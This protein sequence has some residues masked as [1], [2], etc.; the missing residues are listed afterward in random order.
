MGR[1]TRIFLALVVCAILA[2]TTAQAVTQLYVQPP[3]K[4]RGH[5]VFVTAKGTSVT[6]NVQNTDVVARNVIV[7]FSAPPVGDTPTTSLPPVKVSTTASLA[8]GQI[9]PFDFQLAVQI[10]T[11]NFIRI[12]LAP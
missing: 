6:I 3:F 12:R 10:K 4:Y 5:W 7:E 9:R 1:S 8:P 2:A 11:L